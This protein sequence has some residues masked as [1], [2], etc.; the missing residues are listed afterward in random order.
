LARSDCENRE[1]VRRRKCNQMR[2]NKQRRMIRT[3][4]IEIFMSSLTTVAMLCYIAPSCS[5]LAR[6][7][8]RAMNEGGR[9]KKD[10][11]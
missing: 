11:S 10:G 8:S 7:T 5:G 3:M 6:S 9:R 1:R 2:T 4:M